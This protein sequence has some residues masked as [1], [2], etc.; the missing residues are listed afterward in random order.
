MLCAVA[1]VSQDAK[2][3]RLRHPLKL[4]GGFSDAELQASLAAWAN[5]VTANWCCRDEPY[6][7]KGLSRKVKMVMAWD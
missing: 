3:L 2:V 4:F 6:I 5:A 1:A 7:K